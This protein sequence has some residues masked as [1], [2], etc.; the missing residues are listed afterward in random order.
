MKNNVIKDH[1]DILKKVIEEYSVEIIRGTKLNGDKGQY[2]LY[3]NKDKFIYIKINDECKNSINIYI[4][5]E[6]NMKKIY[7][8]KLIP[9]N[10]FCN[11]KVFYVFTA[12]PQY[13]R[14]DILDIN[15][16]NNEIA[17]IVHQFN[18]RLHLYYENKKETN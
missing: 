14:F 17:D 13:K 3:R 18:K 6:R 9:E 10:N 2:T 7:H 11:D 16:I 15:Y 4:N 5:Y 8:V 12:Y 1:I